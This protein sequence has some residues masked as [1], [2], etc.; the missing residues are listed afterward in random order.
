[1]GL[2]RAMSYFAKWDARSVYVGGTDVLPVA[3]NCPPFAFLLLFYFSGLED[4]LNQRSSQACPW[5]T[6]GFWYSVGRKG[7]VATGA[8]AED[9]GGCAGLLVF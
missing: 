8:N 3:H 2:V 5:W 1:M 7:T 6:S 9:A 4:F